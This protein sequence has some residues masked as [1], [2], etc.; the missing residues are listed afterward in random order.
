M[1]DALALLLGK[2]VEK[3]A[4]AKKSGPPEDL[5]KAIADF[6]AAHSD[7]D[8]ADALLLAVKLA[9]ECGDSDL[10]D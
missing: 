6:R 2:A 5:I 3:S 7:V 9:G 1:A 4:A 10:A 8:A